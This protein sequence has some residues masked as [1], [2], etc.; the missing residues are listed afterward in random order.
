MKVPA[1]PPA[2]QAVG[3]SGQ[4][5]RKHRKINGSLEKSTNRLDLRN[6]PPVLCACAALLLAS[7]APAQN[8]EDFCGA[9]GVRGFEAQP[10]R[11]RSGRYVNSVYGYSV[12]VPAGLVGYT[13]ASGPDRGF[14]IT[15][16]ASPRAYLRVDAGYDA[17]YDIDAAGV[18]RRDRN[19]VRLH[20]AVI[21]DE[22]SAVSL[23]SVAGTRSVMHLQCHGDPAVGIHEAIIVVR[24]REIYRIDLQ[25]VPGRYAQD[26]RHLE[27]V[28]RSWRWESVR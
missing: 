24:N 26:R 15:L 21:S 7:G 10:D 22:S 5:R 2:A 27:A 4:L 1:P 28:M 25:T 20:D 3:D 16:S 18:H 17:F 23:A 13:S 19:T 9:G 11:A 6:S 8:R 14:L 12:D